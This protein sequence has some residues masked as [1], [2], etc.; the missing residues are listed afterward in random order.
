VQKYSRLDLLNNAVVNHTGG[1]I[2]RLFESKHTRLSIKVPLYDLK[3]AKV[4]VGTINEII[5]DEV[6]G[7]FTL[8]ELVCTF[9]LDFLRQIDRGMNLDTL[10]KWIKS[11]QKEQGNE[12]LSINHY[13]EE[14]K[15]LN[16][17]D[18]KKQFKR[19]STKKKE[20]TYISVRIEKQ[21]VLRGEV[22]LH[23]LHELHPDLH[24]DVE[25]FLSL[26]FKD[27][28]GQIKLGDYQI[29]KNIVEILTA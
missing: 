5:E 17:E 28:M 19:K 25:E 22:F 18:L 21:H 11:V 7:V 3:R 23:D 10:A 4:F 15:E 13:L 27:I 20:T 9:Y 6:D 1:L 8:E 29:L 12:G 16:I 14:E 24:L 26:R 2:N